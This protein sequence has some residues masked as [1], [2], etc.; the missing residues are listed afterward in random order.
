[1]IPA[2]INSGITTKKNTLSEFNEYS[3]NDFNFFF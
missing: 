1:M 2:M 3:F